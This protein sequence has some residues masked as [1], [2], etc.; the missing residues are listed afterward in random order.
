MSASS[1]S[2][3]S[4]QPSQVD[5]KDHYKPVQIAAVHAAALFKK[6][7]PKANSTTS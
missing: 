2:T 1:G 7:K 6:A 5:L 4:Q 3:S